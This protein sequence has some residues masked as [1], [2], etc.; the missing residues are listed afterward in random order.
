[1]SIT[2]RARQ[3]EF[4]AARQMMSQDPTMSKSVEEG[5]LGDLEEGARA[6]GDA[7]QHEV[8]PLRGT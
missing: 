6:F 2:T 1:M 3:L 7:V 4:E 5:D 8:R